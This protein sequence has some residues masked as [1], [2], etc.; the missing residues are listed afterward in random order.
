MTVFTKGMSIEVGVGE[1]DDIE[2]GHS[3][4]LT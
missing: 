1:F 3:K 2:N 4:F